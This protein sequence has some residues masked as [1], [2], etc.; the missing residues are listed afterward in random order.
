MKKFKAPFTGEVWNR[1]VYL[2]P[3]DKWY[4]I[5]EIAKKWGDSPYIA[6]K[7]VNMAINSKV[8]ITEGIGRKNSLF[9][10]FN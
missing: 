5:Q 10:S 6:E 2:V 1:V 9:L 3:E 8:I 4:S 7:Y